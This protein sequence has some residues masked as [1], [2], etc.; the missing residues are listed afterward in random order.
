MGRTTIEVNET[1]RNELRSFK[2]DNG[3]T[4]DEALLHLLENY[5]WSF[6]HVGPVKRQ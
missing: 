2:A 5:G 4:Y 6:R 1:T 3:W